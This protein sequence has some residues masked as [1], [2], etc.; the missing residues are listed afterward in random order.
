MRKILHLCLSGPVTDGWNYQDNLLSKY[1][2]KLGYEVTIICSQWIWGTE[3]KIEKIQET[4]YFNENGVKMIRLP[5]CG[6]NI[7]SKFKHFI[8][9]YAAIAKEKPD[10]IF[11][12]GVANIDNGIITKYC[13]RNPK[14]VLYADNHADFSNS[15]TNWLSKK[16][17]HEVIWRFFAHKLIPYAKAF[18]GV[19][20]ARVD[21]LKEM[22]GLPAEKCKLLV[23]GADD[24]L[25]EAA[26]VPQVKEKVRKEYG[27]AED[28]F[29]VMTGGKIDKWK[30]QTLLLMEAVQNIKSQKVKLVV[31]GSVVPEL[32]EEVSALADGRKVQYI[33]WVQSQDS[34]KYFAAADLVV[35][36]GRHSVFWEQV[37]GQGIPMLVKDWPG[38]HHVDLGG[39]IEFLSKDSADEMKEK[40]EDICYNKYKYEKMREIAQ[41]K[42]MECF[43]Y[44]KIAQNAIKEMDN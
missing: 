27:I 42:G 28:D 43:S 30:T 41:K 18:Y 5:L 1:H 23:M 12:H 34:Y 2:V 16:V 36:P 13:K 14:V 33:G 29:L 38:T 15:A 6:G 32:K 19:L 31:F 21:F 39:N 37:A 10:I 11:L 25:V 35:F 24:E 7:Q 3:G 4:N 22:Y 8:G 17:L 40:I 9:L 26:A 44:K 20:P